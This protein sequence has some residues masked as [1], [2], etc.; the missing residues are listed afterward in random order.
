MSNVFRNIPSVN[1]LLE[2]PP[3]RQVVD[4][5]SHNVVVS[6]VRSFLENLRQEVQT[7]TA[8]RHVPS[9]GELAEKI[10]KWI[11][12]QHSPHLRPVINATGILLHTGLGRAPLAEE[13]LQ[14]V[15]NSCQGYV[16]LELDL[17]TGQRSDRLLAVQRQLRDLTGAEAALVVN[18]N[19][20][21]TMLALAALASQREVIVS[22][23]ELVEIGGSYRLPD[24]MQWSGAILRE[25]GTTNRT[26]RQDYES[27]IHEG[28]G[29]LMKVHPSNFQV[30]GFT[31]SATLAE[32]IEV[33]HQHHLPVIDDI[34]SG[35]LVDFRPYGLPGEPV[36]AE[37]IKAGADVVL[38]SGDKML[39]GPQ[40]GILVGRRK[41]I[42]LIARHPLNRA[43][44]VDKMTLAALAGTLEL[45][46]DPKTA[47]Q[48]IPL[49]ALLSTP[50]ENLKNRADRLAP[51]IQ[52]TRA[53]E[54]VQVVEDVN[55]LGGGSLPNQQ[56]PT[57]CLAISPSQGS[58][59][60]LAHKLRCGTPSVV[61]RVQQERLLLDLRTI[62][63]SQDRFVV[64]AFQGLDRPAEQVD[65]E[66]FSPEI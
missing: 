21:A 4:R 65:P 27:A 15:H 3:L 12:D 30:V 64:E 46:R 19:A 14:A 53:V 63:P 55:Y 9:A 6:G 50:L 45:Y 25:V 48:K 5:V 38:L 32:L 41:W 42:D 33:A 11:L 39:G 43:L 13:A 16:S 26:R 22:R 20:A 44:R 10:A 1:E 61:G 7:A 29:A 8:D 51:Q 62:F 52:A 31:E 23:G 37:R 40:C 54:T 58:V 47:E 59:T 57:W 49:L 24:V 34:G 18:N 36:V 60:H 66:V 28:T 35:S 56:K 17:E 2:S